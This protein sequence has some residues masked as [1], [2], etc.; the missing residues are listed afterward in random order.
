MPVMNIIEA[1]NNTL[2]QAMEENE[3]IV[4]FGEDVGYFGGVFRATVGLQEKFGE[5]RCFDTPICEQGIIGFALGMSNYGMKPVPEIQFADYMFPA[6]DQI[7][8]EVA[9]TRYRTGGKWQA[10]MVIRTPYGGGI[11]G[12]HYHSQSPEAQ[13][14]HTPGIKLVIPSDPYETKG[15]LHSALQEDDPVIFLEPKRI[16]RAS[17]AEVP[18]EKYLIPL[19]KA[20]IARE[21]SDLTLIGYGAQHHE[22]MKAA[23]QAS[24]E[25]IDVEVLDLRTLNPVDVEAIENSVKKTGRCVV[26]HEAPLTMGYGAELSAMIMERCFLHL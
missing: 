18:E 8:N 6:Y 24:H 14:L 3:D 11:H 17:K 19:G 25:G 2:H 26:A 16:Y 10:S 5:M 21:G 1:I 20:R 12:G 15:L 7:V 13:Y 4:V 23:E 9:K 22:N